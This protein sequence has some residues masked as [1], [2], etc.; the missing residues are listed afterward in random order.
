MAET[1]PPVA[2][3]ETQHD[4]APK[5]ALTPP[6][7]EEWNQK[8]EDS[9]DLSDAQEDI[10]DGV[11]IKPDHYWEGGKVPV[12]K[13][14]R[15]DKIAR[16]YSEREL[17]PLP[18]KTMEQFRDFKYFVQK[19]DPYGMK[20]GIVK[21]IP[22]KEWYAAF[23]AI[24]YDC[25]VV[26][27]H[28]DRI[29][30]CPNLD[31]AIKTIKV[32]NPITQDFT[33]THGIYTQA[34]ME[35]QRSYNLPEW[36]ALTEESQH[37]PPAR[38]GE[39]RKNEK[40]VRATTS[41]KPKAP[42]A[43]KNDGGEPARRGRGRPP[44][45]GK[46]SAS[47]S[48]PTSVESKDDEGNEEAS[49]INAPP[50]PTSPTPSP[51]E[52]PK[53]KPK[54][55]PKAKSSGRQSKGGQMKSV[56][57]RR[58]YN[59]QDLNDEIDEEA[60]K[61]FDY[62]FYGNDEFTPERCAE[63]ETLYW[64]G[65]T[66]APPMYGADMPGSLFDEST[67]SWNVAHLPNLL[68]VL[69]QKVPGVNTAY[70][71]LGMWKATFAWHLE[72]VDLYS[73]NYIHFGAPKQWYSISQEDA[74]KF[75]NAMKS[76]WPNDAKQCSEFLRH[77]TYLVSP[78]LLESRFGIKV[79]KLVHYEGEFVITY[80]YG[81][82][83][84]YNLGY[85]C[86]ESVNFA[87]EKWLDYA[88]LAKHCLC[89]PD[90]VWI[91]PHYIERKYKG[92]PSPEYEEYYTDDDDED[93][94]DGHPGDLPSPPASIA[95]KKGPSKKR[96]RESGAVPGRKVKKIKISIKKSLHEPCILCPNDIPG[97]PLLPTDNGRYAHKKCALYTPETYIWPE[98]GDDSEPQKICN[99]AGIEKSRLDLKCNYC[100]N[101]KGSC[102]QCCFGK[103]T[104][105][106]HATCADAAGVRIDS[107][108]T[109][110]FTPEGEF[111]F[112]ADDFRCPIHR[113]KRSKNAT[114]DSLENDD[115]ITNNAR[116]AKPR[117]I[118]QMQYLS[119]SIFAGRVVE[120]RSGERTLLVDILPGG[121]RLE[122]EWK[123]VLWNDP[124]DCALLAPSADA[125][126]LPKDLDRLALQNQATAGLP[127]AG[128]PFHDPEQI[129]KWAEFDL[130]RK[131]KNAEQKK[132][133]ME[134]P[135]QLWHFIGE[136]ST[137]SRASYTED[138]KKRVHNP[139]SNF[140]DTV[141][142]PPLA[143]PYMPRSVP[144]INRDSLAKFQ[145]HPQYH[146]AARLLP[147]NPYDYR[148]SPLTQSPYSN[149][150]PLQQQRPPS[151]GHPY[152][153]GYRPHPLGATQAS[154][155]PTP[156]TTS[157]SSNPPKW[158]NIMLNPT[159]PSSSKPAGEWSSR[160]FA[161]G[162]PYANTQPSAIPSHPVHHRR[163]A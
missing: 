96:K 160:L 81:Y 28:C 14:V 42:V 62:R 104:K 154:T 119:G 105:A 137:E 31:E 153:N 5:S 161:D 58:K 68:D 84:G 8:R 110:M 32:K 116:K 91:D 94:G 6:T 46:K 127:A 144:A 80:P 65:L 145:Q 55:K 114:V 53:S 152:S 128:E 98:D 54:P 87:T 27:T 150:A 120:N 141:R 102:F 9:S 158:Q 113:P 59:Q 107:C 146:A 16:V 159:S 11:E 88:K 15:S 83:S 13:P 70:L 33:G 38:R 99:V 79:N 89:E 3:I 108:L 41:Q 74:R 23:P 130:G 112:E 151:N 75:E 100:R 86:A 149:I 85:N 140:V 44:K 106:Y 71:Y 29:E 76:I 95:S 47:A 64:K 67:T 111:Y 109:S 24:S 133:N 2:S 124:K 143:A 36:K 52:L 162:H 56:S 129:Q 135:H 126:P 26:L 134:K 138:P 115:K 10:D 35:K 142:P 148:P 121:D 73:I 18:R 92:L 48:E 131:I 40:P 45:N 163:H 22:P 69:G 20:S 155:I 156:P 60:Y 37:Q 78:S 136:K 118:V 77:K 25:D 90:S 139:A 82:H 34:N 17:T 50:T 101:K 122:V 103:C 123:Y 39:R 157:Q 132:V 57:E 63:L 4:E 43:P 93:L 61:D 51:A 125:K 72:D 49:M 19:I 30:S 12:F 7:S 21:V 117:D 97:E 147:G 1:D 66:F